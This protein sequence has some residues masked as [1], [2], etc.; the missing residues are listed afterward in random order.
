MRDPHSPFTYD[1]SDRVALVTGASSGLGERMAKVLAA[2]GA[3]V[4]LAARRTD[5][6]AALKAE[7]KDH[8]GTA[9]AVELDVSDEAQTLEAYDR[10]AGELGAVDTV[11]ANAGMARDRGRATDNPVED[12]QATFDVNMKGAFLT[13][14]EGAKRMME[15]GSRDSE[16]GRILIISSITSYDV[17]PNM[18]FY[19]ASK[20]GVSQMGRVLALDWARMGVNVN[21]IAP[22]YIQT[23]I[24]DGMFDTPYGQA[25]LAR[26][27]RRRVI[28]ADALDGAVLFLCSDASRQVTGTVTTID[29]G[30]TLG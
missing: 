10:I 16:R 24:N 18:P 17:S 1:L 15:N 6:L 9:I 3:K 20:A 5:R 27:P 22:G 28:D 29:D 11:V 26:W 8:G 4:A 30:Q 12:F 19:A 23:E 13:A 25:L 14:R 21:M 2:H 7:I